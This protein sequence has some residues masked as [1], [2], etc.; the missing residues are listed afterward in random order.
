MPMSPLELV[1]AVLEVLAGAAT[2]ETVS[3]L[4]PHA[5]STKVPKLAAAPAPAIFRNRLRSRSSRTSRSTIPAGWGASWSLDGLGI[6]GY[7]RL[8][9]LRAERLL[10]AC[11]VEICNEL[12]VLHRFAATTKQ[13]TCWITETPATTSSSCARRRPTG[14]RPSGGARR[15]GQPTMKPVPLTAAKTFA[16]V[17]GVSNGP[18]GAMSSPAGSLSRPMTLACRAS[19]VRIESAAFT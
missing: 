2:V 8:I 15:E 3:L 7:L 1:D 19:I 13:R 17:K 14:F 4:L 6:F 5:A 9:A 11:L 12:L 18:S 10:D 16:A